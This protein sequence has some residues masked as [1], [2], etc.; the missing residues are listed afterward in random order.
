LNGLSVAKSEGSRGLS[1]VQTVACPSGKWV[2]GGGSDLGTN[3]TQA[4]AQR[5]VTVSLNGPNGAGTGWSV[6]LFNASTT[7]DQTIDLR[8]FAICATATCPG[9]RPE[10]RAA[11]RGGEHR[12]SSFRWEKP[13][14]FAGFSH[15]NR[16][17]SS[18]QLA[19]PHNPPA[20]GLLD[21]EHLLV[22][23]QRP[24]VVGDHLLEL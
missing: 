24:E 14:L 2:I 4:P 10:S 13:A 19:K 6:Q 11:G 9:S 18:R 20:G 16:S 1:A 7:E 3:D 8:I 15:R 5:D 23:R 12:G 17:A 21:E 22:L